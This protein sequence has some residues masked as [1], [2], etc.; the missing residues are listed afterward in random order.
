MSDTVKFWIQALLIPAVLAIM[1]FI[2]N[3]TLQKQQ[4]ELEKIKYSNQII[5]EIFDTSNVPRALAHLKLLPR[6]LKDTALANDLNRMAVTVLMKRAQEAAKAGNDSVFRQITTAAQLFTGNDNHLIDSL[7][8]NPI[9]NNAEQ[10]QK[11]EE[12]G[13]QLLNQG[14]LDAAQENF[15]KANKAHPNFQSNKEISRLLKTRIN[16][17]GTKSDSTKVQKEVIDSIRKNYSWKLKAKA[18]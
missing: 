10:A 16:N 2:I 4:Q 6:L 15:E 7:K 1:G 12:K 14:K 17:I 5:N 18:F 8:A 11:L 3:G 13:L 9:T